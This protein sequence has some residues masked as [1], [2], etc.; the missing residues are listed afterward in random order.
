MNASAYKQVLRS[1]EADRGKARELYERRKAEVYARLPRVGELDAELT[2]ISLKAARGILQGGSDMVSV[3]R[4]IEV[5]LEE[6]RALMEQ[7]G[8]SGDY[9]TNVHTC[10][11]CED[12]GY[13]GAKKCQ[14]LKQRLID[15]HYSAAGLGAALDEENFQSFEFKYYSDKTDPTV[16]LSP[17]EN[18]RTVYAYCVDFVTKF[19]S[20]FSNLLF[21]G[22][23]GLGKTFLC[24]C[25]TRD[26]LDAGVSVLYVTAPM[27]FKKIEDFRF[28]RNEQDAPDEQLELV[29]DTDLLI[30]DDLGSEFSTIVTDTELFNIINSRM[31]LRRPTV[32]STNLSLRDFKDAY[33]ERII[34]RITGS[35]DMLRLF[36][37]DIRFKKKLLAMGGI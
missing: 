18:I 26:L 28:N 16:G 22:E 33:T 4:R 19:G 10:L 14:C 29:Y 6:K 30:I 24:N 35:Y 31:L 23:T 11:H 9:L 27:L 32:I 36:G 13:I 5:I 1:Y 12:T 8:I 2:R 34:S 15:R 3:K 37:D 20:E 25:I 17:L 7:A 21:Y